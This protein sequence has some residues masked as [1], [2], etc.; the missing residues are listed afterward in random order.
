M[1]STVKDSEWIETVIGGKQ[2][3]D[4]RSC[5]QAQSEFIILLGE[6]NTFVLWARPAC[7]NI[8]GGVNMVVTWLFVMVCVS[9]PSSRQI[10][11]RTS[12]ATSKGPNDDV[13][14]KKQEACIIS[15]SEL[16]WIS[17][18]GRWLNQRRHPWYGSSLISTSTVTTGKGA[19]MRA[20]VWESHTCG[21]VG[22]EEGGPTGG[23][24]FL[25]PEPPAMI[26][27]VM[28]LPPWLGS[29]IRIWE[30]NGAKKQTSLKHPSLWRALT[31]TTCLWDALLKVTEPQTYNKMDGPHW[32]EEKIK[33]RQ[34]VHQ[35]IQHLVMLR[36]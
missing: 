14:M 13:K 7:L 27:S 32:Y 2:E 22:V 9:K 17:H 33:D 1:Q 21:G 15:R 20:R 28:S 23:V 8:C 36:D 34:A 5:W 18:E 26:S 11:S 4:W 6:N 24:E 29:R 19:C 25:L 35:V 16:S 10:F 31:F 3:N 30:D 12:K